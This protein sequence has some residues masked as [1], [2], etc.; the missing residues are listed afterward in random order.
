M[1][2]SYSVYKNAKIK[3]FRPGITKKKHCD[4]YV[5]I[6]SSNGT[7]TNLLTYSES[8]HLYLETKLK[9][10]SSKSCFIAT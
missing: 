1:K 10:L 9:K 8:Y 5:R 6:L 4:N 2:Y 7:N 3:N